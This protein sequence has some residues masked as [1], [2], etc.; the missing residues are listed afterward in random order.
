MRVVVLRFKP[1]RYRLCRYLSAV[2]QLSFFNFVSY[3]GY[4]FDSLLVKKGYFTFPYHT[5]W[6]SL[7]FSLDEWMH[8]WNWIR[9]KKEVEDCSDPVEAGSEPVWTVSVHRIKWPRWLTRPIDTLIS[10][11][12]TVEHTQTHTFRTHIHTHKHTHTHIET[13]FDS[14]PNEHLCHVLM[15]Q[16]RK[17]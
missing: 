12:A 14:Q 8:D 5:L 6:K 17:I 7:W 15:K 10:A 13:P 9:T 3:D 2:L 4:F 11:R 16:S 1:Q